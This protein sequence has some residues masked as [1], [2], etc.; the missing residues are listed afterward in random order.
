MAIPPYNT[1]IRYIKIAK[2]DGRGT[3]LTPQLENL[4]TISLPLDSLSARGKEFKVLSI[5]EQPTYFLYYVNPVNYSGDIPAADVHT[6]NY[7]ITG[8]ATDFR[9]P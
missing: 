1:K 5:V 9:F 3:N 6:P 8:S 7:D 2:I 4:Q